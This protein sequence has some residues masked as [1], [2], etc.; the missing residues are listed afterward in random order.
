MD[1][2]TAKKKYLLSTIL[3]VSFGYFAGAYSVR[4]LSISEIERLGKLSYEIYNQ[5]VFNTNFFTAFCNSSLFIII[6]LL[7]GLSVVGFLAVLPLIFYKSYGFGFSAAIFYLVF[8]AKGIIPVT[9]LLMPA[10]F[11]IYIL[12]IFSGADALCFS[13]NVLNGEDRHNSLLRLRDYLFKTI[14]YSILSLI[15]PF[16]DIIV[17]PFFVHLFKWKII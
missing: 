17:Y 3:A 10:A 12:L 13:L 14:I 5:D 16:F 6:I 2:I 11:V 8:G 9:T 1:K 15:I 4:G 7:A